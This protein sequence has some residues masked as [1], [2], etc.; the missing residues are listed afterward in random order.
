M[1][2]SLLIIVLTLALAFANGA[3]D[4]FKGVATLFGS[5]TTDYKK[6]LT[7]ATITTLA[8]SVTAFFFAEK[9]VKTFSGKGL[10]PDGLIVSPEFIMAVAF[11]ASVTILIA[12]FTGI[13]IS[14]THSL[15][16]ALVG[17]GIGA[18]GLSV[19]FSVLGKNFFIPLLSSP[20]IAIALTVLLYPLL[21][22]GRKRLG[23]NR[24]TCVCV[25][26]KIIPAP[27]LVC[28][29]GQ[30]VPISQLR[31]MNIF[32]DE[33][34]ACEAKA[35]DRYS[36]KVFGIDAQGILDSLHFLSAGA[37]CFARG[38]NDTPKIVALSVV[39]GV[40]GLK[41]NIGLVAIAMALGGILSARKVAQTMSYRITSMNHGQGF[42]ANVITAFLVIFASHLGVPVSTT[43]VSCGALFGIGAVNGQAKWKTIGGIFSAWVLTLPIAAIMAGVFYLMISI[44]RG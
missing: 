6:A 25:G 8:G 29:N 21:R 10:L 4:N 11:G 35:V 20:F 28:T 30:T 33:K 19:N 37:V 44:V 41:L 38:L 12:T 32:V 2:W 14:T 26:E 23:I 18:I 1:V 40:L 9:L 3:N 16:G 13:P 15:T 24:D 27:G 36:G 43:H 5:G 31:S 7:W 42:T 39:V 17:A 34:E 22:W